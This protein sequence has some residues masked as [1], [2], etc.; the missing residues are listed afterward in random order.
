MQEMYE[1]GVVCLFGRNIIEVGAVSQP[2][3]S[4]TASKQGQPS[5]D[6]NPDVL[7]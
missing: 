7:Q 3:Y 2:P 4:F 5:A 1:S 6:S